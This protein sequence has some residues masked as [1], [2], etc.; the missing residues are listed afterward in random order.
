[1]I[2]TQF[3]QEE[4]REML[5]QVRRVV[6]PATFTALVARTESWQRTLTAAAAH[7]RGP[8]PT[9]VMRAGGLPTTLDQKYF[10]LTK[11]VL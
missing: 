6:A 11:K 1:M 7:K 8:L 2:M 10:V 9:L 5:E 3:F 4:V